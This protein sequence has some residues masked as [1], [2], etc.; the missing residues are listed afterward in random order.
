MKIS[1][2]NP[3]DESKFNELALS[4]GTIFN[5]VK[6][7]S[8]FGNKVHYYGLYNN[9]NV[10][11]GGFILHRD[12]KFGLSIY[13]NPPF[14]PVI[15]PFLKMDAQ[16]PTTIMDTWK[17][18]LSLMADF[19]DDL[20]RSV[21][22][23]SL[24]TD[25]V[26]TQPFIWRKFKV[27]P[28]YTYFLDLT[29]SLDD[30]WKKLSKVRKNELKKTASDGLVANKTDNI[31]CIKNLVLKTFSRQKKE[32][33]INYLDKIL[34]DFSNDNNSFAFVTYNGSVP[35]A[36][37]LC[38]YHNDVAYAF[39]SGYDHEQIHR[40]AGPLADWECIK[41]AKELGCKT[42]DFEGSMI[43]PVEKYMRGFGGTLTPYF[44]I[45]KATLP[46]EIL[47]KFIKREKF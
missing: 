28:A 9:N 43:Q 40:G 4:F 19:L 30:L 3:Q 38:L 34:F 7:T 31:E 36:G 45:N 33:N 20:P 41:Y 29:Q 16:N 27:I 10:L 21:I 2:L 17:E 1:K 37:T 15:G 25:I 23:C 14:T 44:T 42:F 35:V 13:R 47:L 11:T 5:A 8:I 39:I 18:V 12:N 46:L 26:D 24:N 32:L 6:W 22:S